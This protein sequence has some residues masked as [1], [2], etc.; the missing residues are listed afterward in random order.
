MSAPTADP[1]NAKKCESISIILYKVLIG[2]VSSRGLLD[3]HKL[4]FDLRWA[5]RNQGVH[6]CVPWRKA[7]FISFN[8]QTTQHEQEEVIR[9]LQP[10]MR[11][12][13]FERYPSTFQFK[14]SV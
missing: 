13:G 3:D 1:V 9:L 12:H 4:P 8:V 5:E 10:L 2:D 7:V 14:P 6:V 11:T